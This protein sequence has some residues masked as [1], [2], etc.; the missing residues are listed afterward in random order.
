M[1]DWN[2]DLPNPWTDEDPLDSDTLTKIPENLDWLRDMMFAADGG[3]LTIATGS[4]ASTGNSTYFTVDTEADAA[5]DDLDTISG[6]TEGDVIILS[7]ASGARTVVVKDGT[8]NILTG[9]YGDITL[10][11]ADKYVLLRYDGSNW[12]VLATNWINEPTY[13]IQFSVIPHDEALASGDDQFEWTVPARL[14]G[15]KIVS[16]HGGVHTVS[17]SGAIT[18]QFYHQRHGQDILSTALTIDA[19]EFNSYTAATPHVVNA[20]YDDL[21]T[22]DRIRCD[23]DGDG[24]GTEGWDVIIELE[25]V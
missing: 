3:E 15:Y 17:S 8:G 19:T 6:G 1:S 10:D 21:E 20:S 5:S 24:T 16:I 9:G 12:V 18:F 2:S 14:N 22:G 11:E 7:P 4:I 25:P 13:C 23:C